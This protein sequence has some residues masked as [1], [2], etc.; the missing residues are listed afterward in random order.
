MRIIVTAGPTRE[1]IDSVRYITNASSGKMGYAVAEAAV[2]AG[3]EVTLLTGTPQRKATGGCKVVPFVSVQDLQGALGE[4]FG[5]CDALVM[6]AAVGDFTAEKV[7]PGKIPRAGG[8]ITLRLVPTEDI[9]A[10]LAKVKRPGQIIVAFAVEDG[11]LASM[12]AKARAEMAA[13]GSDFTVLNTPAAMG[14]D[15]SLACILSPGAVAAPWAERSKG[16]LAAQIVRL[17]I[18]RSAIDNPSRR[19]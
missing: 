3:H 14:Q 12:E 19:A 11:P 16:E 1:Y 6:A 17:L 10:R 13:K 2:A 4:L 5:A 7:H 8:P 9:L 15:R 18:N